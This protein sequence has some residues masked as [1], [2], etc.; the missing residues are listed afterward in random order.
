[1]RADP[2]LYVNVNSAMQLSEA[3][4][5]AAANQLSSGKR[6]N[7]PSQDPLAFAQ[8]LRSLAASANIDT[9]T[10]EADTVTS[11]AQAADAALS[12][13]VTS[14]T[15]AISVGT[16]AGSSTLTMAQ[17]DALT[18]Q[19]QGIMQSV[20]AAANQSSNGV[21]LFGGPSASTQPFVADP[22]S[23][24]AYQY[25]GSGSSSTATVGS[26]R[27]VLVSVAGSQVFMDPQASVLGSLQQLA[28]AVPTGD[29][30]Q[31]A[32]SVAQITSAIGHVGVIRAQYSN[33][34]NEMTQQ[35]S[36]LSQ[37]TLTL[38]SQ[39]QSLVGAD[40]AS[41]ATDLTQAQVSN[42]AVLAVAAKIL[43]ESLLN[44]LH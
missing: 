24:G 1:M 44:Y 4:L 14:L 41:A 43:P 9:Y 31:I 28:A 42:S 23:P 26:A 8:N 10:K 3:T 22:A 35:T 33:T 34:V 29:A 19:V 7:T 40:M 20:L 6:V 11:Q 38:T 36:F 13:V 27:D 18:E 12:S 37:E 30:S 17:R 15:Q 25:Q 39:Q 21:A 32:Q 2:S 5:Q 16:Q